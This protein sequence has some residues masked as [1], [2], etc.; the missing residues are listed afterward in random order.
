MLNDCKVFERTLNHRTFIHSF[1]HDMM[2]KD[3]G[4]PVIHAASGPRMLYR[5]DDRQSRTDNQE[6]EVLTLD[7]TEVLTLY[8][9]VH[10]QSSVVQSKAHVPL[11][12]VL[13]VND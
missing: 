8:I 6:A 13:I 11:L 7:E 5:Q 12:H 9:T 1:I 10:N 2:N 4:G 3:G